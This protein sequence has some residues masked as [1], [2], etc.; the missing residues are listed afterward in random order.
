MTKPELVTG[1]SLLETKSSARRDRGFTLTEVIVAMA[2]MGTVIVVLLTA[3]TVIIRASSTSDHAAKV[4]AMLTGAAD[5][6]TGW[7]YLSCPE[8]ND[9]GYDAIVGAA[10]DDVGWDSSQVVITSIRYWDPMSGAGGMGDQWAADGDWGA[11]NGLSSSSQCGEDV[12]LTTAR[13]LQLVT[14]QATSPDGEIVRTIE[15]VK[16]NVGD[17]IE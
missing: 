8:A 9:E 5:R 4:E 6:L 3:I 10:A 13:T 1:G 2:L 15:V 14:I 7:A 12:S 17:Q 11:T 16:A